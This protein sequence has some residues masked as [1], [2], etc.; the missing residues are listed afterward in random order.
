[1]FSFIEFFDRKVNHTTIQ[2]DINK[3]YC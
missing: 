3:K 2:H 1:M